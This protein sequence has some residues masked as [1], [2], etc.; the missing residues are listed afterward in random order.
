MKL[1]TNELIELIA[2]Y[3]GHGKFRRHL[4]N[5]RLAEDSKCK[6]CDE[7]ETAEH[8]MCKYLYYFVFCIYFLNTYL[9]IQSNFLHYNIIEMLKSIVLHIS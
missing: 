5:M 4:Q 7:D 9:L 3:T 8:V 6:F 2:F 1:Q